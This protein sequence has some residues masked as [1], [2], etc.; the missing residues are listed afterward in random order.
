VPVRPR[1]G[2]PVAF[3]AKVANAV[4]A[5]PKAIDDIHFKLNG[6]GLT[7]DTHL[8]AIADGPGTYRAAFTF[9]EAGKY[10]MTFEARIDGVLVR[11]MKQVVAGEEEPAASGSQA[12]PPP[13]PA[14]SGKW[15]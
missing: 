9:F 7:P 14:P 15:L 6:P 11:T 8:T 5:P 1:I 12:A 4:G 13:R 2:Q 10:E 3:S